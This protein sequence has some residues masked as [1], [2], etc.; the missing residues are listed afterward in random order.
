MSL[1]SNDLEQIFFEN[2]TFFA[3]VHILCAAH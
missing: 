2:L 3:T 1:L